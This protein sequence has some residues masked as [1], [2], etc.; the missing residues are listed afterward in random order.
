[1]NIITGEKI[2]DLCDVQIS[3]LEHKKFE[4]NQNSI[5]IDNFNFENFDNSDLVYCNISLIN[6]NKPKL[7][8]SRLYEKLCLFKNPFSLVLHN[9]DDS[10]DESHMK[11]LNI[12]NCK[13]VYTQNMNLSHKKIKPL[14]IGIA[15][16]M[17][18]HGNLSIWEKVL[19][20]L[21]PRKT[22]NIYFYLV[23]CLFQ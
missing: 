5:D 15:N 1:M 6:E 12:P 23:H 10:F 17:W 8:E 7:K 3:K 16:S 4:S 18:D 20:S 9:A 11:Y 13:F 21:P 19:L 2:Q 14:P 22:R